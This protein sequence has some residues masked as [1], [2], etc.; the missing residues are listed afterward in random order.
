MLTAHVSIKETFF[1]TNR[2]SYI[3]EMSEYYNVKSDVLLASSYL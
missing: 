2:F 1:I 3:M